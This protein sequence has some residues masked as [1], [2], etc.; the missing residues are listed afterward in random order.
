MG[1]LP[2]RVLHVSSG[3]DGGE[4]PATQQ[5]L[6]T[7]GNSGSLYHF[8]HPRGRHEAKNKSEAIDYTYHAS[9]DTHT[10]T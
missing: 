7:R 6:A 5:E 8:C 10:Q 3:H 9:I 4:K 1:W 2:L